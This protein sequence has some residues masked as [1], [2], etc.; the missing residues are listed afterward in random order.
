MSEHCVAQYAL[1]VVREI[2]MA[3]PLVRGA[4]KRHLDDLEHGHLRGLR[5]DEERADHALNFFP[6]VLRLNGGD[7]EGLPFELRPP[8]EFIVGSLFGWIREDGYRRFRVG[9]I[10]L[11]KGNGKSVSETEL[12]KTANGW[13]TMG[14]VAVGDVVF[15]E[16]G[17]QCRVLKTSGIMHDHECFRLEFSDGSSV[18]ADADHLWTLPFIAATVTSKFIHTHFSNPNAR[19]RVDHRSIV[20]IVPVPSVPVQCI[21]VDSPS[22]LFLVGETFIPTHNSPLVAGIGLYGIVGDREPRAE[23]YAAASKR[24][25]AMILFRDAVAMVKLSPPLSNRFKLSGR[26][27]KVWNIFDPVTNSFFRTISA[28]QGQS[29]TRPHIGLID[30]LHEHKTPAVMNMM[31]AGRKGRKQP[32]IIAITN[33]GFDKTSVCWEYHEKSQKICTY[34]GDTEPAVDDAY[35]C[36]VAGLDEKEDPFLD[37]RCWK[38]ANPLLGI[39]I[40][41]EY[42]REEVVAGRS[43]P[44]KE[45]LVRRLNFCQWTAAES[46]LISG[47]AWEKAGGIGPEGVSTFDMSIFKGAECVIGLDLSAVSDL[48]AAVF[49]VRKD[50]IFYWWPEF[51]FPLER[52]KEKVEKDKVPYDTWLKKGYIRTTPGKTINLD[53]VA[54]DLKKIIEE[55]GLNVVEVAYDRWKVKDFDAACVRESL[56]LEMVEF[57]QGF[58]DMGPAIDSIEK[59]LTD[60]KI[61]HNKNPVLRWCAANAVVDMD[62]AGSRKFNK[63][64]NKSKRIDG[65]VA[66]AMAHH[67]MSLRPEA[68]PEYTIRWAD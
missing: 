45:S 18:I 22:S 7:F 15:D 39:T 59:G 31:T 13:K 27:D 54:S 36:Y 53:F 58:K 14:T 24:E 48:T 46:P 12:I 67:R 28:D 5:F 40:T 64:K 56:E 38:K 2:E 26:D 19:W 60:E 47:A 3:G 11:G 52:I 6:T 4:C 65:I 44:S 33:S 57:G 61:R 32:L 9:Y 41:E 66:A 16:N 23:I 62:P 8:Q 50:G 21:S 43:M 42:L 29:G 63:G 55:H 1:D 68:P 10:E 37:E 17:S 51:W 30:E 25:Q 49:V 20:A 35:F 34:G